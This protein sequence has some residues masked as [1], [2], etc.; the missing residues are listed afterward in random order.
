MLG[1]SSLFFI[2]SSVYKTS[3]QIAHH[4]LHCRSY[5]LK[6]QLLSMKLTRHLQLFIL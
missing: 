2:L 5:R 3:S 1:I 4:Y 6:A